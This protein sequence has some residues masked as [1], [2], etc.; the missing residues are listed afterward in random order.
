MNGSAFGNFASVDVDEDGFVFAKF[1]NGI[2]RKIYQ[3]PVATF[4]NP[5][6]LEAQ[7]GGTFT[8]TPESG[9][10]TLTRPGLGTAGNIASSTLESSNV[11]LATEFTSLIT[12][13][14]AY[15]A[16]SKIITTADEMLDEAI[17]MK[18]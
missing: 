14:R 13:Q 12:T 8:V 6:G 11:D 9:A 15:S 1:T 18:R 4:T 2:V 7:A 10:Y 16:S 5:D 17:R 3:I